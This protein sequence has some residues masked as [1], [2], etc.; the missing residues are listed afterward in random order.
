MANESQQKTDN[1]IKILTA[2]LSNQVVITSLVAI[3]S[4][5]SIPM[6]DFGMEIITGRTKVQ[7]INSETFKILTERNLD[8]LRSIKPAIFTTTDKKLV[9]ITTCEKTGDI[10][11]EITF[12]DPSSPPV[13]KWYSLTD[14]LANIKRSVFNYGSLYAQPYQVQDRQVPEDVCSSFIGEHTVRVVHY[15][16]QGCWK[17]VWDGSRRLI[18]QRTSICDIQECRDIK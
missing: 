4:A 7:R 6:Y 17:F 10:L 8:C 11:V 9:G 5:F 1:K 2:L 3:I 16:A 12:P 18:L 14:E 15:P 13:A